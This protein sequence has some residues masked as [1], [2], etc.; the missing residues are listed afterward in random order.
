MH[1]WGRINSHV[2]NIIIILYLVFS[3]V[4]SNISFSKLT[5]IPGLPLEWVFLVVNITVSRRNYNPGM[6][7]LLWSESWAEKTTGFWSRSWVWMIHAFSVN[8][9]AGSHT[10]NLGHTFCRKGNG[11]MKGVC[12]FLTSL[13]FPC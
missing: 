1:S 2:R 13:S 9:K 5:R 7:A 6:G 3:N 4:Q 8:L 11:R 10:F 12:C